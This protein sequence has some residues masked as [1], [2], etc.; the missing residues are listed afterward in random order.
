MAT[1]AATGPSYSQF[2]YY[3]INAYE[4]IVNAVVADF[5]LV[6]RSKRMPTLETLLKHGGMKALINVAGS[7]LATFAPVANVNELDL[8]YLSGAVAAAVL[9]GLTSGG[10]SPTYL[11]GEQMLI[12]SLSHVITTKS[13][14]YALGNAS[15]NSLLG[16]K[17]PVTLNPNSALNFS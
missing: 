14:N 16:N 10:S 6:L 1:G 5:L 8:E 12:S 17:D 7:V 4:A 2:T 15:L 11:A 13:G 3:G 9:S